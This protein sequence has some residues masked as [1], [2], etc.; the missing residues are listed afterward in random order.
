[1]V[2]TLPNS[3]SDWF[4]PLLAE[5]AGLSYVKEFFNPI[6]N[7]KY[8][9]QLAR[10]FGCELVSCYR[11]IGREYRPGTLRA[12]ALDEL[13]EATWCKEQYHCSKDIYGFLSAEFFDTHF[14]CVT[15]HK[16]RNHAFPPSRRRVQVYYDAIY[17][18]LRDR[19]DIGYP[20]RPLTLRERCEFAY[21]VAWDVLES[22]S[23]RL[24]SPIVDAAILLYS[25]RGAIRDHLK[26]IEDVFPV[27]IDL[28]ADK[29]VDTRKLPS[30]DRYWG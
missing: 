21:D 16:D 12:E 7:T 23:H 3:G 1:M 9:E 27:D 29:V 18:A 26:A 5:A 24:G 6:C 28:L 15:L 14:T 20:G 30:C 10:H 4:A 8:R 13:Y 25:S 11:N 17:E 2:L 19:G 22:E